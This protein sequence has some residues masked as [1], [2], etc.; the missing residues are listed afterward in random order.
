MPVVTADEARAVAKD[1][2]V[3][4]YPLIE[5][6]KTLHKQALDRSNLD[7]RAPL[8]EIAS[9]ANVATPADTWVVTPNADTPYSFLWMD[10]R[11]EPLVLTMPKIETGR[12]YSAQLID[13]Q[14]FNFAYLGTRAFG[15]DGGDFLVAGPGWTGEPPAGIKAVVQCETEIAYALF[16]TQLFN[17]DDLQNVTKIQSGYKVQPLSRY[18]GTAAPPAATTLAWPRPSPQMDGPESFFDYLNF[19]LQF[20]PVETSETGLRHRF[21]TLGSAP[22]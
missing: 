6:Y 16:R 3:Y 2:F 8:N 1:A 14:T 12:Y 11:A 22:G 5:S 4:G 7:Y 18:L 20:C 19:L 17:C 9:A 13:L 21:A 15:N 10:L